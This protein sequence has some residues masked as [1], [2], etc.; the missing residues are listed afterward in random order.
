MEINKPDDGI[1]IDIRQIAGILLHKIVIIIMTGLILGLLSLLTSKLLLK[2]IYESSTKLYILNRQSQATTTY[3]DIQSASQ[4][5]KD[6]KILITSRTVT[7]RVIS[8]LN[9]NMTAEQLASSITVNTPTDTRILEI[10]VSNQDQYQAKEIADKVAQISSDRICKIM[11]IEDVNIV[12]EA[13]FPSSPVSPNVRNNTLIGVIIGILLASAI[14][15]IR[16]LMNDTI[17]NSEDIERYLGISTLALIPIAE[18]LS[19]GESLKKKKRK[20]KLLSN[21]SIRKAGEK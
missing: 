20:K 19:D 1:E 14:V 21:D 7:E 16:F 18:E 5:T 9:L 3:S 15:V 17:Q 11:Q 2:P 12:D 8:E 13:N 10:T 4:L 6:Y